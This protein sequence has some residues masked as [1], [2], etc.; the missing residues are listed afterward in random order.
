MQT[1]E[2][3][4]PHRFVASCGKGAIKSHPPAEGMVVESTEYTGKKPTENPV[5]F[6]LLLTKQGV[7]KLWNIRDIPEDW[8][9]TVPC[10]YL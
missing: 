2:E 9:R 8:K 10:E 4:A 3:I 5:S 6:A 7:N 1:V